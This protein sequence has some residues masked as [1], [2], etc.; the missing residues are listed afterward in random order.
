MTI[1]FATLWG[2]AGQT[3]KILVYVAVPRVDALNDD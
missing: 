3:E 1:Q 2:S